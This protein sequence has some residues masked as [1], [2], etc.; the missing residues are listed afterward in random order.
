MP[1][2]KAY[3]EGDCW[4]GL[5][6][7]DPDALGFLYDTFADKLFNSALWITANRELAKDALH[8]V[9]VEIWHYRAS[10]A[11]VVRTYSYLSRVM[12]NILYKK[13]KAA[14][15]LPLTI[16]AHEM[17]VPDE[18]AEEK[19]I[20]EN[21]SEE[22]LSRLRRACTHL[23]GRQQTV[24]RLRFYEGLSYKQIAARL[25]MNYQSVNNL[26]FRTLINIRKEF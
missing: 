16:D 26:V 1:L 25:R 18:N 20:A 15:Q 19:M 23:T 17:A 9:F 10:L 24:I 13:L 2:K 22:N 14:G 11:N 4:K 7:G 5:A 12:H 8:D 3:T 6:S 21:I